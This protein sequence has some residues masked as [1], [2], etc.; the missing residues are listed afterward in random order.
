MILPPQSGRSSNAAQ[1]DETDT[2]VQHVVERPDSCKKKNPDTKVKSPEGI[3][4]SSLILL[5]LHC[6]G[7]WCRGSMGY[8]GHTSSSVPK[9]S[10]PA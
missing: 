4:V 3:I 5:G 8:R 2:S 1:S 7:G 9:L 6:C 10:Y